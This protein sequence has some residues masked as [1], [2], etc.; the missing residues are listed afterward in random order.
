[1]CPVIAQAEQQIVIKRDVK[2]I[3]CAAVIR[4]KELESQLL[5]SRVDKGLAQEPSDPTCPR[6]ANRFPEFGLLSRPSSKPGVAT[7]VKA[8]LP[9]RVHPRPVLASK[10]QMTIRFPG[11]A[12]QILGVATAA[13][14]RLPIAIATD[15][16][17]ASPK[18]FLAT[19]KSL[20]DIW[21]IGDANIHWARLS[22]EFVL[23]HR[24]R[25]AALMRYLMNSAANRDHKPGNHP[26]FQREVGVQ[27]SPQVD[28]R[29]FPKQCS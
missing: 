18:I 21:L 22:R 5:S 1:M 3:G 7:K 24:R 19:S 25:N 4:N 2:N 6:A 26:L 29:H 17:R 20:M 11:I 12:S 10:P 28:L 14:G 15:N 27:C 16:S 13:R 8:V 23:K 9:D